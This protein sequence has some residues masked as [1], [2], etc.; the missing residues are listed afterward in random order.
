[1]FKLLNRY[2]KGVSPVIAVVLLI[3]LTVAAAA[4]I[5]VIVQD[6]MGK[7][8]TLTKKSATVSLNASDGSVTLVI[9]LTANYAGAIT[10]MTLNDIA[11]NSTSLDLL[12]GDN[13]MTFVFPGSFTA[14]TYDLIINWKIEGETDNNSETIE[15]V[16]SI[17]CA[18]WNVDQ[19]FQ[20][21]RVC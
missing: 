3:A 2:K 18:C 16:V 8:G 21:F 17:Q 4:V 20:Q 1:M 11:T 9:T 14:G 15:I 13:P 7:T 5:W 10:S 6:N 19:I 12:K